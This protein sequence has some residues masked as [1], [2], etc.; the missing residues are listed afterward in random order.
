MNRVAP[1][2]I[3]AWERFR[4]EYAEPWLEMSARSVENAPIDP[5]RARAVTRLDVAVLRGLLLDLLVTGEDAALELVDDQF[6]RLERKHLA[7]DERFDDVAAARL[8]HERGAD[9]VHKF[10]LDDLALDQQAGTVLHR[11]DLVAGRAML[12]SDAN[13]AIRASRAQ[14]VALAQFRRAIQAPATRFRLPEIPSEP[15]PDGCPF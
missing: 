10:G 8:V 9:V 2:V 11:L 13:L 5:D 12:E 4:A 1:Q 7:V 6:R 15:P 14:A 3:A